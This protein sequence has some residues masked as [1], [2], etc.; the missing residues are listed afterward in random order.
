M[1]SLILIFFILWQKQSVE[2][3]EHLVKMEGFLLVTRRLKWNKVMA[4]WPELVFSPYMANHKRT[5][6]CSEVDITQS[7]SSLFVRH[8]KSGTLKGK[9][10]PLTFQSLCLSYKTLYSCMICDTQNNNYYEYY[11]PHDEVK[12]DLLVMSRVKLFIIYLYYQKWLST[13]TRTELYHGQFFT[14]LY[15]Y[16]FLDE[17]IPDSVLK[18][19]HGKFL[20]RSFWHCT[21]CLLYCV[22][23]DTSHSVAFIPFMIQQ[24]FIIVLGNLKICQ[25]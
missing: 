6:F 1:I 13:K 16:I 14:L 4:T 17:S 24:H 22:I 3:N 7:N 15:M 20:I 19:I 10:G 21:Y 23:H 12:C 8:Y 11:F 25:R 5:M 9:L 18:E 2:L